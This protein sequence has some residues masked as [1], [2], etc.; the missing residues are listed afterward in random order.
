MM[1]G[2]MLVIDPSTQL[3]MEM[4]AV[5]TTTGTGQRR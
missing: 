2:H 3:V 5:P 4:V 1:P